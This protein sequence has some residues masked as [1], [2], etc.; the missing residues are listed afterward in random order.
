MFAGV[1]AV[2]AGDRIPGAFEG[3]V[4]TPVEGGVGAEEAGGAGVHRRVMVTV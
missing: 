3:A 2:R 1:G 4:A